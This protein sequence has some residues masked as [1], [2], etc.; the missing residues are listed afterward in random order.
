MLMI[1]D[2][3]DCECATPHVQATFSMVVGQLY[4]LT[5]SNGGQ[6]KIV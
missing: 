3:D 4:L 2:E 6:V 5:Q 1:E